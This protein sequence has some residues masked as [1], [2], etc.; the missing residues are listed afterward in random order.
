MRVYELARELGVDSK[1]VLEQA[2]AL[3]LE[4]KTASSGID[5]ESAEVI[6][7]AFAPTEATEATE[8]EAAPETPE[9]EA[10]PEEVLEEPEVVEE[11]EIEVS[12]EPAA[13]EVEI[14]SIVAGASVADFAEAI[15]QPAGE[16]VKALLLKGI[17][18]GAGHE[19]PA[20]AIDDIAESF[21]YI[22]EVTEAPPAPVVADRP[23]FDDDEADLT[24]R[25]P[26]GTN[27]GPGDH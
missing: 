17:P 22:V 15:G 9:A 13:A 19:M 24:P 21:G 11:P 4:V 20:D 18:A 26:V 6:R 3:G 23:E 1:E 10:E 27:I 16:V 8:P 25:P 7:L 5:D 12:E 2:V 14:A